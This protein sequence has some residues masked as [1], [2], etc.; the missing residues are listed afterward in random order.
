MS[1]YC[2]YSVVAHFLVN[3]R[4]RTPDL[5]QSLERI[6]RVV[7]RLTERHF[8]FVLEKAVCDGKRIE[9]VSSKPTM[10]IQGRFNRLDSEDAAKW[11]DAQGRAPEVSHVLKPITEN[12]AA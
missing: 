1:P 7:R 9:A 5:M 3:G 11:K 10:E 6:I 8:R 4:E 2:G 12:E